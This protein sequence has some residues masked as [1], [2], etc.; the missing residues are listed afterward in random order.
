MSL[1]ILKTKEE[2]S[3]DV[4]KILAGKEPNTPSANQIGGVPKNY[5]DFV[6][7]NKDKWENLKNP[8]RTFNKNKDLPVQVDLLKNEFSNVQDLDELHALYKNFYTGGESDIATVREYR[9]KKKLWSPVSSTYLEEKQIHWTPEQM[10]SRHFYVSNNYVNIRRYLSGSLDEI[11][12]EIRGQSILQDVKKHIETLDGM[13]SKASLRNNRVLH[14]M[15]P[16]E[17]RLGKKLRG[18]ELGDVYEDVSYMSTALLPLKNFGNFHLE[19]L[20]S[21]GAKVLNLKNDIE[22]EYLLARGSKFKVLVKN[23]SK[24]VLQL[25]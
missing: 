24:M 21:K 22:L 3:A 10:S 11:L 15:I 7:Q 1:N 18:L 19:I 2:L 13:L 25:L 23:E 16:K 9:N 17:G 14:R 6:G 8:P 20:A 12:E 4:D 5:S